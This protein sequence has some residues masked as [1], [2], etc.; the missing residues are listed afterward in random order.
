MT[1]TSA[2]FHF[3][4]NCDHPSYRAGYLLCPGFR[5]V[6]VSSDCVRWLCQVVMSGDCVKWFCQVVMSGGCV[7]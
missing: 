7:R 3:L 1:L 2:N 4:S 5:Q 6:V